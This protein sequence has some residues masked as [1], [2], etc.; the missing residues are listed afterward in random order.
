MEINQNKD[1]INNEIQLNFDIFKLHVSKED[2]SPLYWIC[3]KGK[4]LH[5][6]IFRI[7]T[8]VQNSLKISKRKLISNISNLMNCGNTCVSDR[9]Y[10]VKE[11]FPIIMIEN[12]LELWKTYLNKNDKQINNKKLEITKNTEF[13][14]QNHP[15]SKPVLAVKKL[16][17]SLCELA[18][19]H[20]ADGTL[21][22]H[23]PSV[24][25]LKLSQKNKQYALVYAKLIRDIFNFEPNIHIEKKCYTVRVSNKIIARYLNLFLDFPYGDKSRIVTIPRIIKNSS[26][27]HQR[28][29]ACGVMSYEGSVEMSGVISYG[30]LS[31][32]LRDELTDIF[33]KSNL[34]VIKRSYKNKV[35][36]F[37]IHKLNKEEARKWLSFFV[38]NA[39]KWWKIK[40][41]INGYSHSVVDIQTAKKILDSIYSPRSISLAKLIDLI[42][43]K[44]KGVVYSKDLQKEIKVGYRNAVL[45]INILNKTNILIPKRWGIYINQ[46]I[47]N[48]FF[49]K[50]NLRPV[51]IAKIL[52]VKRKDVQY[53]KDRECSIPQVHFK[54]LLSLAKMDI[55]DIKN[56]IRKTYNGRFGYYYNPD[57]KSWKLPYRPWFKEVYI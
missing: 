18:G 38:E 51:E 35:F 52:K 16:T 50:I 40:D 56:S 13:L 2:V 33:V 9:V 17:L 3:F 21:V 12:L 6:I 27:G 45:M 28:A 1:F 14:I 19:A 26:M 37:R 11:K 4:N 20:A 47:H 15:L 7:F 23:Y 54:R 57:V 36:L 29:F 32:I 53:W 39:E 55:K 48:E 25:I 10:N 49:D 41:I 46:E 42:K 8:E 44:H 34:K 30:G 22:K 24:H 43:S 5:K 31:K